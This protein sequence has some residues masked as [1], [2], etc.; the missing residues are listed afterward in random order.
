MSFLVLIKHLSLNDYPQLVNKKV[1]YIHL[2][3][4][5]KPPTPHLGD[6]RGITGIFTSFSPFCPSPV[7]GAQAFTALAIRSGPMCG[8]FTHSRKYFL[9]QCSHTKR[10]N[11][12]GVPEVG[13]SG[14]SNDWCIIGP[15]T[16]V[17]WFVE[18]I[19][20]FIIQQL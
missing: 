18:Y 6:T 9:S 14:V 12:P 15:Q 2:P 1:I 11:S 13:R 8:E 20:L 16:K 19:M 5:L 4:H 17:F 7:T 10:V 3:Y